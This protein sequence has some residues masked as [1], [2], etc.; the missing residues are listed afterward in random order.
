MSVD[1]AEILKKTPLY[2]AHAALGAKMA[3]FGGWLMPIQYEGILAEHLYT[4]QTVTVFDICHMGEFLLEADPVSSGLNRIVTQDI[5]NMPIGSCRYGFML[6]ESAGVIDDLI[7][8]RLKENYWMLVVNAAT[9]SGDEENIRKHLSGSYELHNVSSTL[10]KLDVQGPRSQEVLANIFGTKINGLRY[11][12]FGEF[13][14]ENEACIISC[15]GYTGELGYEVYIKNDYAVKLWGLLLKINLVKPAGL[16]CRDTLRLEM[17]YPLYGHE[18]DQNHTPIAAGLEKFVDFS[19]DFI[20][21]TALLK[22]QEQGPKERLVCFK[23]DSRR[24]PRHGFGI[25]S[26]ANRVGTVTSGSFSPSL[27]VGIG[28]GYICG[29]CEIGKKLVV[30]DSGVEIPVTIVKKPFLSKN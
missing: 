8:Y 18:L 4:R 9:I 5:V 21:K 28:M 15:T 11:Y 10:G 1:T 6:N 26:Q 29:D 27:A 3:G 13:T 23:A 24:A 16:G 14:F 22:D 20:G 7:V 2:D 25:Y 12:K 17:G 30:K 19:K